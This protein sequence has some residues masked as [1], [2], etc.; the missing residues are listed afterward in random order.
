MKDLGESLGLS[1]N[2]YTNKVFKCSPKYALV[3]KGDKFGDFQCAK[4]KIQSDQMK[5][6]PLLMLLEALHMDK[7]AHVLF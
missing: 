3:V 2:I 7:F 6:I 5:L 1:Q 4:N